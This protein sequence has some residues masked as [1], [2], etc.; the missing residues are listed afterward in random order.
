LPAHRRSCT[1]CFSF[2]QDVRYQFLEQDLQDRKRQDTQDI[3]SVFILPILPAHRRPAHPVFLFSRCSLSIFGTG[4]ARSQAAGYAR[5]FIGFHPAYLAGASPILHILFFFLSR[6]PFH[7][8]E[9]DLQDRKRQDTQDILSVFIL[10]ICRR[11]A[12]TCSSCFSFLKMSV[13]IFWNRIAR[14]QA[15]DTQDILSVFILPILPAHRRSC[16]SCFSFYQDVRCQFLEQDLQDRKR[17]DTQDILSVFILPILPAHRRSYTS[18]FS[19]YQDVRCQFLEQDLQDRKRQDTQ[20]IYRFSS[21]LSCRRIADPAHPVFL[22]IRCPFSFLEQDLQ[23][24]KRQDTQDIL[25][26]S[27]C[28]SCRRIAD[29][30]HPVFLFLILPALCLA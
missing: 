19:F 4:F 29:L 21:C 2:S 12:D 23:D 14:L 6:C 17:Q 7:F 11:I 1:S 3:L 24:R 28:Q 5:Y 8:L 13:F 15:Q 9:H 20:D 18:C 26:V 30:A 22:F 16:T 25:S 27:S 10:P